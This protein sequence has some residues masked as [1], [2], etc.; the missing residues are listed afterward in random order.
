MSG[1]IKQVLIAVV[2]A[3]MCICWTAC[4]GGSTPHS[5]QGATCV[6]SATEFLYV[7]AQDDISGFKLGTGGSP[8]SPQHQSG[9]NQSIGIVADPS[10]KFLYVS[11]FGN[12]GI[13]AF[14]SNAATGLLTPVAGSPFPAS[15]APDPAGIRHRRL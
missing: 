9:P 2:S 4:G 5:C 1:Y 11:D 6:P 15:S 10:A 12:G 14:T 13:E 3:A 8:T 7:T